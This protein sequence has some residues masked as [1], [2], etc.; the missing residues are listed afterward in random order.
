MF[1]II[2]LPPDLEWPEGEEALSPDS[3]VAIERL[4]DLDP[5]SRYTAKGQQAPLE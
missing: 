4:L 2:H 3:R 5:L 1:C